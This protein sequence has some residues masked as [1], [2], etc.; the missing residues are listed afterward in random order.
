MTSTYHMDYP[1]RR[2]PRARGRGRPHEFNEV[3]KGRLLD[4]HDEA[5]GRSG[6]GNRQR[7]RQAEQ[8][9]LET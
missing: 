9:A 3:C 8:I 7:I 1:T 6:D 4:D 5:C 2:K